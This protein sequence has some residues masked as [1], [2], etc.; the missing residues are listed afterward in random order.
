MDISK[1]G[2]TSITCVTRIGELGTT[3]AVTSN[4]Q[5]KHMAKKYQ[6]EDG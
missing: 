4:Q 6:I 1:E 5:P 3:S 2:I